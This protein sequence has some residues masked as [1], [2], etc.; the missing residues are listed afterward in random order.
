MDL[1]QFK[2]EIE[3]KIKAG[4]ILDNPGK[5]TSVI[6][7]LSANGISYKR[8]RSIIYISFQDFFDTLKH[9]IGNRV[10]SSDLKSF[11][12][13]VFDSKAKRPGH[14]CNCTFLFMVLKKLGISSEIGGQG[15]KGDPYFVE[16]PLIHDR[17]V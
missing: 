17:Q 12:P 13:S 1:E 16:I 14:S 2:R 6:T 9:F 5:G 10:T 3:T 7:K 15:I 8:G 4:A 11:R